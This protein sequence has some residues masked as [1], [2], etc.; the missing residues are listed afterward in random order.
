M[1]QK[2]WYPSTIPHGVIE[3]VAS[4]QDVCWANSPGGNYLDAVG[5][6]STNDTSKTTA[7]VR[8]GAVS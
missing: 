7:S 6:L 5:E 1:P 3:E 8:V 4:E 2:H